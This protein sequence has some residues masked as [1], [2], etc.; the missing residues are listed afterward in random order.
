MRED[1]RLGRAG[2]GMGKPP[3]GMAI[4]GALRGPGQESVGLF[5]LSLRVG[6]KLYFSDF[7]VI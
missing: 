5:T 7:W 3:G 4:R 1:R 6:N 2:W